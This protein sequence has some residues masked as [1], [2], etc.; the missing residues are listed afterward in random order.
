MIK[1][2]KYSFVVINYEI[3]V[4]E[5]GGKEEKENERLEQERVVGIW[6]NLY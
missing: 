4:V 1:K 6:P 3:H 5:L 2:I